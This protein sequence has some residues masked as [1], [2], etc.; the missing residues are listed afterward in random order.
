[1]EK[2]NGSQDI[3]DL[4]WDIDW[5]KAASDLEEELKDFET[6]KVYKHNILRAPMRY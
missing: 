5:D 2:S 4:E 3:D 6:P 1:M